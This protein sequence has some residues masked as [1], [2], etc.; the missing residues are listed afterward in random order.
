M[1]R[2]GTSFLVRSL[3]LS[4]VY[5]G[6]LNSII[7][8]D[9]LP[10][11]SNLRG[12]WENQTILTL[13]EKT[14]ANNKGKWYDPPKKIIID[15]KTGNEI[16]KRTK[17]LTEHS[18]LAS[19]FKDTRLLLIFDAWK[20]YLPKNS[21]VV[22]IFRDPLKVAESLKIRSKFSY[23]QSL[24]LW[25]IYNQNL[26]EILNQHDGFLLDFDWSKKKILEEIRL[27]CK[28]LGLSQNVNL[29]EWYTKEMIK[30]GKSYRKD[31]PLTDEIKLIYSRLKKRSK[32]NKSVPI[33]YSLKTNERFKVIE[34]LLMEIQ[35]QGL[36][37]KKLNNQTLKELK[38]YQKPRKRN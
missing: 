9:W 21:V 13:A 16:K 25:K 28:K 11:K 10:H 7:T 38:R 19:G 24:E 23:N 37:F 18:M 8:H 17:E 3:N 5:L 34:R 20:K 26:L 2:S 14:L 35:D 29:E 22:G 4:G 33:N 32:N 27:V 15:K 6:S 30:S 31:Y 36:Y 12:H 1:H